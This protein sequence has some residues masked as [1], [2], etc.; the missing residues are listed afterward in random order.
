[1]RDTQEQIHTE[2]RRATEDWFKRQC[3]NTFASMYFYFKPG[4]VKFHISE[5]APTPEWE[6]GWNERISIGK[7]IGQVR[8]QIIEIA[9][10]LP[11]FA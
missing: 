3:G 7:T 6:L 8:Y 2:A 5:E 1:M 9:Q 11:L 4:E 10:R